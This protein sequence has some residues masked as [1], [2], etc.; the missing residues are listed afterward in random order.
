[1]GVVY[2]CVLFSHVARQSHVVALLAFVSL[3]NSI[4][5]HLLLS[6]LCCGYFT[7]TQKQV[8]N[9]PNTTI[10]GTEFL[11]TFVHPC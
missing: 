2:V 10:K 6:A 9:S 1:M 4:F 5:V 8:S 7:I 3:G 11:E